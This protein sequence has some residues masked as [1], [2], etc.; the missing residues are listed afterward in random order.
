[1]EREIYIC[2]HTHTNISKEKARMTKNKYHATSHVFTTFML[3]RYITTEFLMVK[4]DCEVQ[5]I[6]Q[7]NAM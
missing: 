7:V 1:M 5:H 3:R 2:T 6:V 4:L